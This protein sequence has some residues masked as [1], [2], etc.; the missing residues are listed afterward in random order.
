MD[1]TSAM[2]SSAEAIPA[3]NTVSHDEVFTALGLTNSRYASTR[4]V[5]FGK[6]HQP[7][8]GITSQQTLRTDR[9]LLLSQTRFAGAVN[10]RGYVNQTSSRALCAGEETDLAVESNW[11][12]S[13]ELSQ[14]IESCL[15]QYC[16]KL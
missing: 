3:H 16:R 2:A 10:Q 6:S 12:D 9:L 7:S 5:R 1:N 8:N 4:P 14:S 15:K 11:R 13:S